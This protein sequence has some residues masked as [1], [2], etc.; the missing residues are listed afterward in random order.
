M[1][2]RKTIAYLLQ[3]HFSGNATSAAKEII[4]SWLKESP[5]HE[6][7]Y[8]E[9]SERWALQHLSHFSKDKDAVH[10]RILNKL[11]A[12]Q[13]KYRLN[14][15]LSIVRI[16]A[17]FV[18][19][20]AVSYFAGNYFIP[21]ANTDLFTEASV[22]NGSRSSLR[23]PDG[24]AVWLNAGS[25][26]IYK[27]DFGKE[28]REVY[29]E[30]EAMFDVVSDSLN[31]FKI[32]TAEINAVVWGTKLSVKAYEDDSKIEVTLLEG[33]VRVEQPDGYAVILAPNQQICFNKTTKS[34]IQQNVDAAKHMG[35][36]NDKIYFFDESFETIARQL[37]RLYDIKIVIHSD[38]LK[39]E[40][41]YGSFDKSDGIQHIMG[42]IDIDKQL[43]W[44]YAKDT[45]V[46]F[47]N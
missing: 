7:H 6:A 42:M 47:N 13:Q 25:R 44:S 2:K 24:S 27:N 4:L 14:I 12:A 34:M 17:V 26:L 18:L 45:M 3:T 43:R 9:Y 15:R 16:A 41:F 5:D 30:G 35:W 40:K 38:K 39:K 23:L 22:P 8:K 33:K 32:E 37:E 36:V 19:G 46:I 1:N 11:I 20:M 28:N 29:L 10:L 31:P 21:A